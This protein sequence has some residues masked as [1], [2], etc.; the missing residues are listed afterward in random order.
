TRGD[1][2]RPIRPPQFGFTSALGA[3]VYMRVLQFKLTE[4]AL[5]GALIDIDPLAGDALVDRGAFERIFLVRKQA[6]N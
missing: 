3:A 5:D 1:S 6:K 2:E 4:I